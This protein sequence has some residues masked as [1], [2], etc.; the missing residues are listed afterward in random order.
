M[1]NLQENPGWVYSPYIPPDNPM[2]VYIFVHSG[3]GTRIA[4]ARDTIPALRSNHAL[5]LRDWYTLEGYKTGM[6]IETGRMGAPVRAR[7][8]YGRWLVDCPV[9]RGANDVDPNEPI[10]LCSSCYW[11][12]VFRAGQVVPAHFAPVEFPR[13]RAEIE[14]LLLERPFIRNRNWRPG[15]SL[16]D[17]ARQT[18]ENVSEV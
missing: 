7:V 16:A 1:I 18:A 10:Y 6:T 2:E 5:T 12:G 17:L 11:P 15:E 9:C 4:T 8:L 13:Q 3:N 14:R